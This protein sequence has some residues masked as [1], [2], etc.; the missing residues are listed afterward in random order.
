MW[1]VVSIL[2]PLA[3]ILLATHD[4]FVIFGCSGVAGACAA[5]ML[6]S[7]ISGQRQLRLA[8]LLASSILIGYCF[9]TCM[10]QFNAMS[11]GMSPMVFL[12]VNPAWV[13]YALVL[14]LVS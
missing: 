9:G 5:W 6:Y 2:A 14:V 10:V 8:W 3:M 7:F 1:V 11:R 13:A 4:P 12:Q